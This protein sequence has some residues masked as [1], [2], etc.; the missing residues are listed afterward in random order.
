M[1]APMPMLSWQFLILS[2]DLFFLLSWLRRTLLWHFVLFTAW[3]LLLVRWL[4][5]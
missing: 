2:N 3:A 4:G 5:L 1:T